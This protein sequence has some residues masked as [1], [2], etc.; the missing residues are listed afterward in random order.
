MFKARKKGSAGKNL[1][2]RWP[3]SGHI[4]PKLGHFFPILNKGQGETYPPPPSSYALE[5]G[6]RHGD[7]TSA[8]LF[9]LVLEIVFLFIMENENINGLSIFENAFLCIAYADDT[10]FLK[11][12]KYVKESM[13]IVD[14]FSTFFGLKP[15]KSKC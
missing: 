14:I 9:I 5:R 2:H 11:D 13:K 8:Y 15:N 4:F 12:E 10:F 6:T 1:T 7:P 3:Q